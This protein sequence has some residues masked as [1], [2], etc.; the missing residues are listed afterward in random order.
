MTAYQLLLH[1]LATH[2]QTTYA[3][4]CR[5]YPDYDYFT[6]AVLKARRLGIVEQARGKNR[7]IVAVGCCPCCGRTLGV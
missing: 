4:L 7:P 3:A 6:A 5:T 1:E 2:G